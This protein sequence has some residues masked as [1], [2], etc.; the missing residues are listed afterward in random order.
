MKLFY[1]IHENTTHLITAH[2][3]GEA[4]AVIKKQKANCNCKQKAIFAS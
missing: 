1:I 4:M 2:N 3:I